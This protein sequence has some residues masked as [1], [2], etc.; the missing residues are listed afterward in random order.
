MAPSVHVLVV[1]DHG[2][3]GRAWSRVLRRSGHVVAWAKTLRGARKLLDASVRGGKPFGVAILDLSL[4]DGDG[5]QLI[6]DI[7]LLP[8][9]PAIAVVSAN[10]DSERALELLGRCLI[11]VPKPVASDTLVSL[12]ERLSRTQ[13]TAGHVPNVTAFCEASRLSPRESEI[14][15]LTTQGR[16]RSEIAIKLGCEPATVASHWNRILR[17]TGLP[18]QRRVVSAAW[19]HALR[20]P[21]GR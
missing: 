1:E 10:L 11:G 14:V 9:Q 8:S 4:P 12:V 19:C 5:V 2:G 20:R 13:P 6:D 16:S 18:T 3:I 15:Q 7:E 21:A 17:K